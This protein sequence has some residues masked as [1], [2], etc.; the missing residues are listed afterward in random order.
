MEERYLFRKFRYAFG[1]CVSWKTVRVCNNDKNHSSEFC[2]EGYTRLSF[3]TIYF[4][5]LFMTDDV[6]A[7]CCDVE[8]GSLWDVSLSCGKVGRNTVD[9][10]SFSVACAH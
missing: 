7:V 4:V 2:E 5:Q 9:W 10:G 3:R 1:S 6:C 8:A